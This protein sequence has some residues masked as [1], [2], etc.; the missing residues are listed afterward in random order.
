[1]KVNAVPSNCGYMAAA[2]KAGKPAASFESQCEET[3]GRQ[4]AG[5]LPMEPEQETNRIYFGGYGEHQQFTV[6]L[7]D[8]STDEDPIVRITGVS[9][10][11]KFD[12]IRH[13]RDINPTRASYAELGALLGYQRK[14]GKSTGAQF[15]LPAG[16]GV[17]DISK[18]MDYIQKIKAELVPGKFSQNIYDEGNVLLRLYEKI[19]SACN[20][21]GNLFQTAESE[22]ILYAAFMNLKVQNLDIGT[23]FVY[24]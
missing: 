18:P 9:A 16:V 7:T 23:E 13:I 19:L 8:D 14:I 10:S 3:R 24:Q 4:S 20:D 5:A 2:K 11:G 22:R 6:T 17:S 15:P 21:K 1:M 12:Y